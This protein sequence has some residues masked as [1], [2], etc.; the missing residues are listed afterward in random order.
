LEETVE[1]GAVTTSEPNPMPPPPEGPADS[2][3]L[4]RSRDDRVIGGVCGGLG[5]YLGIDSVLV[6]IA[7]VVL[8]VAGGSGLLAYLLAW[9]LIPEERP[10][11][12]V[13]TAPRSAGA[14]GPFVVGALLVAAGVALLVD[15]LVPGF[16][17]V[18]G[19]ALL[20]ALGLSVLLIAK[21]R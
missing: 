17:R 15:Q 6:R 20:I 21:R 14:N 11:D 8:A 1:D 9:L 10:G 2:P 13:S 12:S 3:V 19:P 16:R 4:L 5:R 7:F 18:L